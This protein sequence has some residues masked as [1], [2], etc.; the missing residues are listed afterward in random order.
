MLQIFMVLLL[1]LLG[2]GNAEQVPAEKS[3]ESP[4]VGSQQTQLE[5]QAEDDQA[6]LNAIDNRFIAGDFEYAVTA[7]TKYVEEYPESPQ[8]WS[9]LGWAYGKTDQYEIAEECFQKAIQLNPNWD[10]AYVG[11]GALYRKTGKI[12]KAREAYLNA[13][14]IYPENGEAYSSLLVLELIE[15]NDEKAVEYGELGWKLRQDLPSI[16]ANLSV[17]YHYLGNEAKRDEFYEH[18]KRLQ[19]HRLQQLDDIFIGK[20][21]IR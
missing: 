13:I 1:L 10:N 11:I 8:A 16:A 9:L 4:S 19:Y 17:A 2:C 15:G 5:E 7:L 6:R 14:K 3:N 12:D 20:M 18:A 21:S